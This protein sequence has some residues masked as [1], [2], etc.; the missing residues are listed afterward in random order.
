MNLDTFTLHTV[1]EY[2]LSESIGNR[3]L[4]VLQNFRK[5]LDSVWYWLL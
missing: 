4:I 2:Y 5:Y 3:D 1:F